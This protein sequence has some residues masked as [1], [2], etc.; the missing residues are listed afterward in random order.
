MRLCLV[1]D[2]AVSGLEPLTLTRPAFD[3][4]LGSGT[5]GSKIAR[6][7]GIGPG[8]ARRGA[9]VRPFL[10]AVRRERDPH[11]AVNDRDWLARGPVVVANGRWAPPAGFDPSGLGD[12]TPWVGLC[13]GQPAFAS[14]GPGDAAGLQPGG[15][16]GWFE[17]IAARAENREVGGEWIARPWDLVARNADHLA[18]D[19]HSEGKPTLTNRHLA[20]AAIVG[21]S[22]RLS[23]HE[24]ARVDPYTVFD[25]T[26]GPISVAAGAWIQPFTRVEGPCSI[27]RDTQLFRANVRGRDDDR[28]ELPDRRRGRGEHHSRPLEQV[29]R[30]VPRPRLRRR[31]GEPRRDHL[32][33]RPPERLRRGPRPARGRSRPDRPGPGRLLRRRPH[34]DRPGEHAQHRHGHR[35]HV[36]RPSPPASSCPSTSPHSPPSSTARSPPD[37]PSINSSP[38]PRPSW[39]G[40]ARP[41]P[42]PSASS[43]S[44]SSI[45]PAWNASGPSPGRRT[46][47]GMFGRSRQLGDS[48]QRSAFSSQP[49]KNAREPPSPS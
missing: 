4:V 12:G 5:L 22:D 38:P 25:T 44:T 36:Q 29:P 41:S 3:L 23:I 15:V 19:F 42:R 26:S 18:R 7:F 11:T 47:V 30:G 32:E 48:F 20:T 9:I 31:V 40:A 35:R 39:A 24:S 27:G 21:P 43:T 45:R 46:V 37:S 13:D 49:L 2:N 10:A 14:V 1:E 34:P 33:Q 6:A 8:P 16:D 28:P 17:E